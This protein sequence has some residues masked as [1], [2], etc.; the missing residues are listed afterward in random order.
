M[1]M[2]YQNNRYSILLPGCWRQKAVG[3]G[4]MIDQLMHLLDS[5]QA[6]WNVRVGYKGKCP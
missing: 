5:R 3:S 4:R 1:D 2:S 6:L